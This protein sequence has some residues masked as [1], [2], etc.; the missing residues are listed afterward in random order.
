M[1]LTCSEAKVIA[2]EARIE[3]LPDLDSHE[4]NILKN[5]SEEIL[6]AA[7][8]GKEFVLLEIG[9]SERPIIHH[10]TLETI[11]THAKIAGYKTEIVHAFPNP[12]RWLHI[13]GW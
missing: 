4:E 10:K 5:I 13:S 1:R 2:R 9:P 3:T 8:S 11:E 6:K 12:S 7:S